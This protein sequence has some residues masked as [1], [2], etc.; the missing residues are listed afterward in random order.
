M[1]NEQ[2]FRDTWNASY[3][4]PAELGKM[5]GARRKNRE[6]TRKLSSEKKETK[7]GTN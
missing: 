5:D 4:A 1:R 2:V 6:E 3:F 7:M